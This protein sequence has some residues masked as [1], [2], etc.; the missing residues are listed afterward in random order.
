MRWSVR[1]GIFSSLLCLGTVALALEPVL[2]LDVEPP[3]RPVVVGKT[4]L[5][6]DTSLLVSISREAV[7]FLAQDKVKVSGG[8]FR[9]AQFSQKG[10]DLNP[11]TYKVEITMPFAGL[12]SPTVQA[13]IGRRGEKN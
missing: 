5:P 2:H 8:K 4:N 13:V 6:D 7:D 11:G 12:Q 9:T 3:S 1:S 10:S